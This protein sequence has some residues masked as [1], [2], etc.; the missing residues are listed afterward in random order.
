[1]D[2]AAKFSD[3]CKGCGDNGSAAALVSASTST[4]RGVCPEGW[5]MPL[6]TDWSALVEASGIDETLIGKALKSKNGWNANGN[7]SD[8]L[9]MSILPAGYRDVNGKYL[10][11]GDSA[12]LWSATNYTN[13]NTAFRTLLEASS[14]GMAWKGLSVTKSKGNAYSVRCFKAL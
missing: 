7:G 10:S 11:K 3:D 4:A 6:H 5:F 8:Y 1:M 12:L 13:G 9:G 14:T 2:S